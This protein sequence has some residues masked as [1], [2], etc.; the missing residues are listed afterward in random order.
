MYLHDELVEEGEED[1][2][3]APHGVAQRVRRG[4]E[5]LLFLPLQQI[6]LDLGRVD[7]A[8]LNVRGELH[9]VELSLRL[10]ELLLCSLPDALR[11]AGWED[12]VLNVELGGAIEA[13]LD[14]IFLEE[15]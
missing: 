8:G 5:L 14:T 7:L 10:L 1:E 13:G 6:R 2:I 11:F 4:L 3:A 15:S 12:H 9:P